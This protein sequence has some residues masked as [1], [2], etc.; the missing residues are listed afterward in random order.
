MQ[1]E[2]AP[3]IAPLLPP[4]WNEAAHEGLAAF[5]KS[6]E[7]VM[8][9]WNAGQGDVRGLHV[10][11]AVAHHPPL[12]KA[13]MT[14]NAHVSGASTLPVRVRELVILRMSWLRYSE[15]EFV[16]HLILG[17]RAGLTEDD[18]QRIQVGPDAPG[19][20][21][22]DADLVRAVDELNGL[23][24][25][26][27]TTWARL[28]SRYDTAQLLDLIFVIGCYETLAMAINSLDAQLE[29]GVEQLPADVRLRMHAVAPRQ[30]NS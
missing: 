30:G 1:N 10:L 11:G 15:Y 2:P 29:P 28:S 5:P 19:W 9:R 23:A 12:A 17:R 13:F 22:E 14:F 18:L 6:Y 26:G 20:E 21:P 25:I 16:Q 4:E 7:F 27:N 3:R 8:S 24:R